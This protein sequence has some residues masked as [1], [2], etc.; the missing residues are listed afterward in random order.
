MVREENGLASA[1]EELAANSSEVFKINCRFVSEEPIAVTDNE[2]AL[3]LYYIA[4]EAVANAVKHGRA[5]NIAISLRTAE[6]HHALEIQD[7]GAGF[8]P[9]AGAATGMGIRIMQY[10]ARVIGATF[11][12]QSRPGS[13]THIVCLFQP[14]SNEPPKANNG[15]NGIA[16]GSA[17]SYEQK[18]D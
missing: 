8:A 7:D 10:R 9:A 2:V 1:L 13:G 14:V 4:L 5:K 16:G 17:K 6:G 11:N 3:H 12:L 15:A 18:S